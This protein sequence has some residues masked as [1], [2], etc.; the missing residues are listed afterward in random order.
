MMLGSLGAAIVLCVMAVVLVQAAWMAW[1]EANN[2]QA[3]TR[4]TFGLLIVCACAGGLALT[5]GWSAAFILAG[6]I[7]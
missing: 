1:V 5:A 3:W 7:G 2:Q 4:L 6:H